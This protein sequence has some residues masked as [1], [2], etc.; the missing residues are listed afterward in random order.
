[1]NPVLFQ[2]ILPFIISC[3]VVIFITVIAE[4][5]GTKTGGILGTIP[6]V[7]VV[8][9]IFIGL[10]QGPLFAARTAI[11]VPAEMGIN[12]VFLFTFS[13][14]AKQSILKAII[15]SMTIWAILSSLLFIFQ[16]N[17]L[18]ISLLIYFLIMISTFFFLE[19][20]KKISSTKKVNVQYT[21]SK[22]AFRGLF[23][24]TIITIA[25]LLSNVGEVISGIFSVF[26]AIFLS[27]MIIFSIEHGH[28]F[29][30]GISKSMIFGTLTIIGYSLAIHYL[31]P[32]LGIAYGTLAA[33]GISMVI[34][35][36][37]LII[38]KRMR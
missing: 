28:H 14:L 4:Q 30:G 16:L 19:K 34:V 26:P 33:Y 13:L 38:F 31:Y 5:Y 1:M 10:N 3:F 2:F 11:V 37:L 35:A 24:G 27:T 36:F 8:A 15:V 22:L 21:P 32:L 7:I 23:A 25:V 20:I 17:N 6:S 29:M 12:I 18:V 9:Y